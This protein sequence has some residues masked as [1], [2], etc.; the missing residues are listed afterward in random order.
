MAIFR[1]NILKLSNGR[2]VSI[3]R[4]KRRLLY[5][6]IS[7]MGTQ[8]V[9]VSAISSLEDFHVVPVLKLSQLTRCDLT[10]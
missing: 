7:R 3:F 9:M 6:S 8:K 5:L 1:P 4:K 10:S 2:D